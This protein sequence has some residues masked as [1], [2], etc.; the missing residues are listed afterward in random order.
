[1]TLNVFAAEKRRQIFDRLKAGA[2]P[3]EGAFSADLLAEGRRKGLP[4]VGATRYEPGAIHL[5]FI[6][7]DSTSTATILTVTVTPPERIVFLPV[8]GWVIEN[9]WQ[10]DIDGTYH[11]ESDAL[12][13]VEDLRAEL[14]PEENAKWFGPRQ[15]KRRE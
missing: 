1:V 5:E 15:A 7:P 12:T 14:S 13:L 6:Y 3:G 2:D 11:F 4:Q 10:G 9:I 8:P